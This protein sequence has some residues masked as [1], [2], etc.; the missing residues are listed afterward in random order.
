MIAMIQQ[1]ITCSYQDEAPHK[2][3][4]VDAL[5]GRE[6]DWETQRDT[7]SRATGSNPA[8][9]QLIRNSWVTG[10]VGFPQE[11]SIHQWQTFNFSNINW[12]VVQRIQPMGT[13]ELSVGGVAPI[14]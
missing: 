14:A 3:F 8:T 1:D 2:Q 13:P 12:H 7:T 9:N 10:I 4:W 6:R 11:L 5:A